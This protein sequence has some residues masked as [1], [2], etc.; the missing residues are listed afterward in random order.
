MRDQPFT[1]NATITTKDEPFEVPDGSWGT[2]VSRYAGQGWRII[3]CREDKKTIWLRRQPVV[4]QFWKGSRGG[5]G[6][7]R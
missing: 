7:R 2:R 1:I 5:R 3:D 6:R 4:C